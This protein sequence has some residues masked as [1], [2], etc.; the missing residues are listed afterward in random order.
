MIRALLLDAAGTLI[1]PAEPVPVVYARASADLGRPLD[2]AEV[3]RW[4]GEV[5]SGAGDPEYDAHPDGDAAERDWW[6][7]IV[8]AVFGRALVLPPDGEFLDSCFGS[9]FDHYADPAAWRVFPEVADVLAGARGSGLRVGVVSNFDRRLHGILAGHG[10]EFE[11]VITSADARARKPDPS[12]FLQALGRL[13]LPEGEVMHAGDSPLADVEG[14]ER[15]GIRGFLL[16]RPR[17]DLRDF[18]AEA[19]NSRRK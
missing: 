19:V 3:Q 18:L 17:N 6:R 11:F 5:F 15:S 7:S 4:F 12:I 2:P 1:E 14:A 8:R 13:G 16:S 10:L 9:L